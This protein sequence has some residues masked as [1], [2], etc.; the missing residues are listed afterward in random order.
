MP[1]SQKTRHDDRHTKT[2]VNRNRSEQFGGAL[3]SRRL[4][5]SDSPGTS[6]SRARTPRSG[7]DRQESVMAGRAGS[8]SPG[9]TGVSRERKRVKEESKAEFKPRKKKASR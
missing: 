6:S 9:G 7:A 8:G 5:P 3:T 4:G 1:K 2:E